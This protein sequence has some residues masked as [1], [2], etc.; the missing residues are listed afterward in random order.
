MKPG[1]FFKLNQDKRETCNV[2]FLVSS[3][4]FGS[5]CLCRYRLLVTGTKPHDMECSKWR[6]EQIIIQSLTGS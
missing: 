2:T 6:P 1:A 4:R 5:D 3:P